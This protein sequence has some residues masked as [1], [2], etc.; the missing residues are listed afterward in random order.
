VIFDEES[1]FD[2]YKTENQMKEFVSKDHVEYYEKSVQIS[3][4]NDLE[5]LNSEEDE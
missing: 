3:Q 4:T 2:T 1:F 5:E